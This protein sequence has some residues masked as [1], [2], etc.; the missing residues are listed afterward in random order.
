[1][2]SSTFYRV[3]REES[4]ERRG[5]GKRRKGKGERKKGRGVSKLN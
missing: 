5:L 1:M 3:E 2:D 4:G